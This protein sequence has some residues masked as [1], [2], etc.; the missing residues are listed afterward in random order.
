MS[1]STDILRYLW[2]GMLLNNGIDPYEYIPLSSELDRFKDVEFY[3]AY[4]HK[5]E[6]TPYPPFSQ[7]FFTISYLIFNA[8]I[9]GMKSLLSVFDFLNGI[10]IILLILKIRGDTLQAFQGALIY[11]WNPLVIIEFSHSGHIDALAIF[12]TLLSLYFLSNLSVINSS[13]LILLSTLTKW[14]SLLFTPLYLKYFFKN[15]IRSSILTIASISFTFSMLVIP[16]YLNSR[17]NFVMGMIYFIKNW[18]FESFLSR[19]IT[20]FLQLD[21]PEETYIAKLTSYLIFLT[22]YF[23]ILYKS[24]LYQVSNV[25]EYSILTLLTFYFITPSIFPWY[26]PWILALFSILKVDRRTWLT[27][28]L[29]GIS[30]ISYIMEFYPLSEFEFWFAYILWFIP[31]VGIYF[32][33]TSELIKQGDK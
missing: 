20:I 30:V 33:H 10:L 21:T 8:S 14:F 32:L 23:F 5:G 16:F 25:I 7:L 3:Q 31:I 4:D 2:D 15:S 13:V 12:L 9:T 17:F 26:M 27:I 1:L 6:F 24:K 29:S 28:F 19:L 11:L 22:S 18:R